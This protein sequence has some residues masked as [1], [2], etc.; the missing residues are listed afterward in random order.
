MARGRT[1]SLAT[2]ESDSRA[3]EYRRHGLTYPQ[4]QAQ[5]G[6]RAVSSAYEA[7]QRALADNSREAADE[8]RQLEVARL[9]EL[10]AVLHRVLVTDHYVVSVATGKVA[11]HPLTGEM[12]IDDGPV[13]ASVAGLLRISERRAK[14]LGLDAPS[15]SRVEV[16]PEEAVDRRIGQLETRRLELVSGSNGHGRADHRGPG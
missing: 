6:Y 13:I 2:R 12:L 7:V 9:D 10:T 11:L 5:M 16:I 8:V 14:L 4:I 1:R 3:L 15:R